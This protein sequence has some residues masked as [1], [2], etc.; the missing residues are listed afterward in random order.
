MEKTMLAIRPAWRIGGGAV[1]TGASQAGEGSRTPDLLFTRQVLY[2]LS[3]SGI[4]RFSLPRVVSYRY[5]HRHRRPCG[6]A[7]S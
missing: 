2:Q 7:F 5:R 3:Y 6:W 1:P 4:Q